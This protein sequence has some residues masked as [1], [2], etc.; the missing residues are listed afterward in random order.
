MEQREQSH[1]RM[2]SAESR[3][4]SAESQLKRLKTN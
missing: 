4:Q 2:S 3:H 1:A